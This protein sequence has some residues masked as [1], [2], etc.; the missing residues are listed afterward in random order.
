MEAAEPG[1]A[2]IHFAFGWKPESQLPPPDPNST[3]FFSK[4]EVK[5]T[6]KAESSLTNEQQNRCAS[7]RI[8]DTVQG[9]AE[10]MH[11]HTRTDAAPPI[12]KAALHQLACIA[13]AANHSTT[14]RKHCICAR[15]CTGNSTTTSGG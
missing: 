3:S 11:T 2:S 15:A 9:S 14:N 8:F 13:R 12:T 1:F 4:N 5:E 6:A 10:P 7:Q